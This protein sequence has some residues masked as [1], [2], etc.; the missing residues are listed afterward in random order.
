MFF[1][2][3]NAVI[4]TLEWYG[5]TKEFSRALDKI[6]FGLTI[7]FTAEQMINFVGYG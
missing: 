5:Q 4:L 1:V 6:N 2:G 3:V 7:I